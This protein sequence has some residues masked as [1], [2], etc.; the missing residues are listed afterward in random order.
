[1]K[2]FKDIFSNDEM[3][4]D[5]YKIKIV[6]DVVYEVYGK[7]ISR[8]EGEVILAGSNPSAEEADEGTDEGVQSGI[9]IVLNQRL[10]ENFAFQDKKVFTGYLKDYMKRLV[11]KL[12][13]TNPEQVDVFKTNIQKFTKENRFFLFK[14]F[15]LLKNFS[16]L[17]FYTGESM[18]TDAG[19]GILDY[20]E[21]E[22]EEFPVM[23]FFKH[24][25]V[26]EKY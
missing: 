3:F 15:L 1:M 16:D 19:L 17:K 20:K 12:Q 25:L 7:H 8:R 9:D 26:E 22:G 18:D 6:D 11:A 10:E 13:E 5:S 23:Y 4:T 14:C 21:I 2:V 24:G